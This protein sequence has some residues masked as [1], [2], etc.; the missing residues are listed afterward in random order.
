[1][2]AQELTYVGIGML[3]GRL[4]ALAEASAKI[5]RPKQ[6]SALESAAFSVLL[7]RVY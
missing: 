6:L 3:V 1:M 2:P 7:R 4:L 5:A